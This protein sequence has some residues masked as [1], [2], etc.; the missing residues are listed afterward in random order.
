VLLCVVNV[1]EGRD[2]R[3]LAALDAA[4]G[5]DL[6]DRHTDRH[7]HRSVFTLV[8]EDAPRRLAAEAVTR[9]SLTGHDG[10]H[11]RLGTLDVVPF[12]P[13]HG[14]GL[15]EAV[16]A[17][18]R[19]AAWAASELGLPVFLYGAERSLPEVRRR[20]WRD[21]APDV[22]PV[23][24]H[25]TAGAVCAGARDV[26]VAYNVWLADGTD[27]ATARAVAASVRGP[28]LRA[29]GLEV[30]ERV[31]VSMNLIAPDALG[32]ADAYDVVAACTAVDGA[33]LVGL[34]PARVLERIPR[35]RW[36]QLDVGT[37]Q[38]IEARL[39]ARAGDGE[40]TA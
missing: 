38:T 36:Q 5:S 23:R 21:L 18:D 6:L 24:P 1:S 14:A 32:P 33:E 34:L 30:G 20:A 31:Q 39:A 4:C 12:V 7:H 10:V 27:V 22:G 40:P 8:G 9:L 11:P 3:V 13:W 37:E 17:R 15:D 35:S 25:P 28:S 16:A 19:F 29:L 2:E 26:L